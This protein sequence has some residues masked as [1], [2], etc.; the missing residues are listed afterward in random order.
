LSTLT[1]E[2]ESSGSVVR[3]RLQGEL[4]L[5]SAS[6]LERHLY[7]IGDDTKVNI[8]IDLRQL[9]FIDSTGLRLILSADARAKVE[10]KRIRL[11]RG[12]ETVQRVFR[13]AGLEDRLEFASEPD[14][15]DGP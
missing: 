10:G 2:S 1:F 11:I 9:E 7:D 8:E 14:E 5:S 3:V 15:G 4:D 13:I 6:E 12:P